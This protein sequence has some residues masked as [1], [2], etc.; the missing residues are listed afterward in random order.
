MMKDV[1]FNGNQDM[2]WAKKVLQHLTYRPNLDCF[3]KN[4]GEERRNFVTY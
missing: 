2:K 4:T 1:L 3:T